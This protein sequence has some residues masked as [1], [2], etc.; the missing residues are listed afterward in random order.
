MPEDNDAQSL[1]DQVTTP[2]W[3]IAVDSLDSVLQLA[4][5]ALLK[6]M[7][8]EPREDLRRGLSQLGVDGLADVLREEPVLATPVTDLLSVLLFLEAFDEDVILTTLRGSEAAGPNGEF[9]VLVILDRLGGMP[10]TRREALRE[11]VRG[12]IRD[13]PSSQVR[14]K[15]LELVFADATTHEEIVAILDE[16][17]SDRGDDLASFIASGLLDSAKR[18]VLTSAQVGALMVSELKRMNGQARVAFLDAMEEKLPAVLG[19]GYMGEGLR[20]MLSEAGLGGQLTGRA[21]QHF[22]RLL[23][24]LPTSPNGG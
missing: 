19:S 22:D 10:S 17:V 15:A 9:G 23:A 3:G 18:G 20:L 6:S 1:L 12:L 5:G 11:P 21:R 14:C 24:Q 16:T 7:H 2:P 13:H 4:M 8:G